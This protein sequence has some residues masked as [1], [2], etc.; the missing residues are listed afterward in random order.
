MYM[1]TGDLNELQACHSF[2]KR[3][4]PLLSHWPTLFVQ[5][6]LNEAADSSA[7]AWAQ[8]LVE[9]GGVNVVRKVNYTTELQR[10]TG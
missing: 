6:A 9:E 1:F 8:A 10:E 4:A 5:Q 7:R 2:L 3:H